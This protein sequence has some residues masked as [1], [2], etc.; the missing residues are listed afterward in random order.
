[1]ID[2]LSDCDPGFG[3]AGRQG[4]SAAPSRNLNKCGHF[5]SSRTVPTICHFHVVTAAFV[6]S[7]LF[8][9]FSGTMSLKM[10][11]ALNLVGAFLIGH[12][13]R[14]ASENF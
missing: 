11:L 6:C 2:V 8:S 10:S 5:G 13:R 7:P 1:M 3:V 9:D 14:K 4:V 12:L